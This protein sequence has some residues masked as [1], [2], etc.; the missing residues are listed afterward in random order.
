MLSNKNIEWKWG[1][2]AAIILGFLAIYPQLHLLMNRGSQ[3]AGAYAY[4][5][6]DEVAYSAYLQSLIDGAPRRNDPYTSRADLTDKQVDESLFSIQFVAPYIAALPARMLGLSASSMFIVIAPTVAI[7]SALMVFWFLALFTGNSRLAAVGVLLVLCL[8]TFVSGQGPSRYLFGTPVRWNYLPFL[9]RYIPAIPFPFFLAMFPLTWR[10]L[11]KKGNTVVQAIALGLLFTVLIFSY[12]YLWSAA[13]AWL[14]CLV[15]VWLIVRP[16]EWTKPL[17]SLAIVA[18]MISLAL[19]VYTTLLSHRSVTTDQIQVLV[20]SHRPELFRPSEVVALLMLGALAFMSRTGRI[21]LKNPGVGLVISVLLIPLAVFNQQIL[22]G[23]SLQPFHYEE[24]VTAYMVLLAAAM[25]WGI[26][27]RDGVLPKWAGS[28][29]IL[30][31]VAV[32]SLAYGGNSAAGIS[33]AALND[34]VVR[35]KTAV[36]GEYLRSR[37]SDGDVLAV[38]PRQAETLPT[39]GPQP[40]LWALHMAVFP[41]ASE[42]EI[43]ERFYHY[44]YYENIAPEELRRLLAARTFAVVTAL[45]G[46]GREAAHLTVNFQPVTSDECEE[47]VRLYE[48]YVK[49]FDNNRAARFRLGYVIV[50]AVEQYDFSKLDNWY[51][52]DTGA[53]VGDFLVYRLK[54]KSSFDAKL[55]GAAYKR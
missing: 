16:S 18:V 13:V 25:S 26:F 54:L 11:M 12:F 24:F 1:I 41:G 23:R 36:V 50:P 43:K 14:A 37:Q 39:Y 35:D 52:R 49:A 44:L 21:S 45:F 5:D 42:A 20:T 8:A 4:T 17:P 22:T 32:I 40:M 53:Q 6:T 19:V 38:E 27:V 55:T 15:F 47:E 3:W 30:F 31:W 33:R 51:V 48:E 28:H 2:L 9:R 46:P 29:R 34:N 7:A 10:L